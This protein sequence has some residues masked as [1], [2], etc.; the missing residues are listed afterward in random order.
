MDEL[1][2]FFQKYSQWYTGNKIDFSAKNLIVEYCKNYSY[3]KLRWHLNYICHSL[4]RLVYICVGFI[5]FL[6]IWG[7]LANIFPHHSIISELTSLALAFIPF[8]GPILGA[9]SAHLAWGWD[10]L[11]SLSFFILPYCLVNTPIHMI[12]LYEIFKDMQRWKAEGK[13]F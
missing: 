11:Y 9:V 6:A 7:A 13:S 4:F 10:W 1:T 12:S 2:L 8:L 3:E 5:Q